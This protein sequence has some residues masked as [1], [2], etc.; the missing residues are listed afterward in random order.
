VELAGRVKNITLADWGWW[1]TLAPNDSLVAARRIG[2][3][4]IYALDWNLPR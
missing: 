4:D 3:G 1:F 2:A